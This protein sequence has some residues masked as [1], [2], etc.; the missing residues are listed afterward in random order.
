MTS[1][2]HKRFRAF[3]CGVC[4]FSP[5]LGVFPPGTPVPP[6]TQNMHHRYNPP[7]RVILTKPSNNI[8]IG[9]PLLMRCP[10]ALK[11]LSS[12]AE[13]KFPYGDNKVY[14]EICAVHFIT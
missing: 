8:W 6:S 1:K 10:A 3:L 7:D 14:P 9:F 2:L 11:D 13:D 5:C 12:N 4:I